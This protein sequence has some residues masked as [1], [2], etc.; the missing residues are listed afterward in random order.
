MSTTSSVWQTDYHMLLLHPT[1]QRILLVRERD[2]WR[3]PSF[4][5]TGESDMND[6]EASVH[7]NAINDAMQRQSGIAIVM[8]YFASSHVDWERARLAMT[9]VLEMRDAH[10]QPPAH[11]QWVGEDELERLELVQP[12]QRAVIAACLREAEEA[13]PLRRAWARRDW[14]A[15]A[16]RWIRE[17]LAHLNYEI[18]GPIQQMR[19]WGLSCILHVPTTGGNIYFKAIPRGVTQTSRNTPASSSQAGLP[20]LFIHE[21]L[22]IQFLAA[23]YPEN[24][25]T[26]LAVEKEQ[27]WM[28]LAEFGPRLYQHS[29]KAVWEQALVTYARMQ[30]TTTERIDALFAAGCIDRRLPILEAQI[31]PLLSDDDLLAELS[32][33]EVEQL[34]AFAHR[35]KALCQ[36][37]A[38]DAIPPTLVHGDLHTG[39][40]AIQNDNP[41]YFDWTDCC[42]AHPFF[43]ALTFLNNVD[44]P[45]ER[46]R[47]R[48]SYLTQWTDYASLD[49]LRAIFPLTQLLATLHQAVSYRHLM[50]NVEGPTGPEMRSGATY[51]LRQLL[52]LAA[53][54]EAFAAQK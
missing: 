15:G 39:N 13:P 4:Q 11:A 7:L 54:T 44:D 42:I 18:V 43:D 40:I 17:Q 5:E 25:P 14:F 33:G 20:L 29:D 37:L 53:A 27:C 45:T 30:V 22:L 38:H 47:L 46:N 2:G 10:W 26:V 3:L 8:L 52:Q 34:R 9:A 19:T 41:L 35:L 50:A 51:W 21:P 12:E 31:D 1:Q 16:G 23:W 49:H 28:L 24:M 48:D 32:G 36:Q 6:L